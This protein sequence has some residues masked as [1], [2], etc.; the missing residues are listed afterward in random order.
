[1][2]TWN[3]DTLRW[4]DEQ[5]NRVEDAKQEELQDDAVH[6]VGSEEPQE[7]NTV[8]TIPDV[9]CHES[10]E[11]GG[12]EKTV[13]QRRTSSPDRR[14]LESAQ[15]NRFQSA[16]ALSARRSRVLDLTFLGFSPNEIAQEMGVTKRTVSN[17]LAYLHYAAAYRMDID[18]LRIT[19]WQ[20]YMIDIRDLDQV[21][22]EM[23]AEAKAATGSA[24]RSWMGL[25]R[26]FASERAVLMRDASK[27][28]GLPTTTVQHRSGGRFTGLL[29]RLGSAAD[30]PFFDPEEEE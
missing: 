18:A 24:K 6:D 29:D 10:G 12:G 23:R 20:R 2:P 11:D 8:S 19:T 14:M 15:P 30:S 21:Y 13:A 4:E 26:G 7:H 16:G 22:Q 17:D 25:A 1:M 9:E 27:L 28:Y 5:G 3:S